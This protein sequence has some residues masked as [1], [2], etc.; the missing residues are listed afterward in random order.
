MK[1]N[2]ILILFISFLSA[3]AQVIANAG[4]DKL[5]CINDTLKVTGTG[6]NA[7][8][9]GTYTWIDLNSG[10]VVSATQKLSAKITTLTT[11]MYE[12]YVTR[13]HNKVKYESRD[14]ITITVS[15]LPSFIVSALPPRC[16]DN[17]NINLEKFAIA[18]QGNDISKKFT[19]LHYFQRYK[20]PS[21]IT[22]GPVG[23]ASY[24]YSF[25]K[26]IANNKIPNTGLRDTICYDYTDSNSCYNY[27]C[28]QIRLYPNPIV[29]LNSVI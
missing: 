15:P 3:N 2:L 11:R 18:R 29:N 21:W 12:L 23:I 16:Y 9:T 22:G 17:G 1:F 20:S 8:D 6:L 4:A 14:T 24:V 7:G 10:F 19:D 13:T 28:R 27:E 25:D 5:I 26:F